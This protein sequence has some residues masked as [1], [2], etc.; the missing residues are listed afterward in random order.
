MS[1]ECKG[2]ENAIKEIAT[3]AKEGAVAQVIDY[4][5]RKFLLNSVNGVPAYKEVTVS[6]DTK[7]PETM[8]VNTL[9]AFIE[10]IK[11]GISNGEITDKLYINVTSPTTVKAVTPINKYGKRKTIVTAE[12]CYLEKFNFS[13][14]LSFE[15]FVISL[16][17]KFIA[18]EQRKTLL[19]NLKNVTQQNELRTEDNGITQQVVAKQGAALGA[20]S[21]SP[22]WELAP[23]RTFT[24]ISQPTSLFLL[25]LKQAGEGSEFALFE[26]DGGKWAIDAMSYIKL[27]LTTA[28]LNKGYDNKVFVL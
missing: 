1:N 8:N 21:V 23:Y 27:Y 25:R 28:F 26:T 18:S 6:D 2:L 20:V 7:Y 9:D 16:Q 14:Y 5:G 4:E 12:R 3:M 17:S 15:D 24:E 11:A 22:I 10:Y 19:E 13:R